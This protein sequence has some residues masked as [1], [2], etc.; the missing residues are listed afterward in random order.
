M[1]IIAGRASAAYGAGFGKGAT[2]PSVQIE[3]DY[4]SISSTHIA[5]STA[6]FT[7]ENIPTDFQ[8]LELR[9]TSLSNRATYGYDPIQ[10][11]VN[12][13]L[14]AAYPNVFLRG[15]GA[16]ATVTTGASSASGTEN[17]FYLDWGSGTT[18]SNYP[19]TGSIFFFDANSS[20]KYKSIHARYGVDLN[21]TIGGAAGSVNYIGGAY[22]G[23]APITSLRFS[24]YLGN[25]FQAG[26]RF[27]L[28]GVK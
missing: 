26:S 20:T 1:P 7:I 18:V 13:D 21:G 15:T 9:Y 28:Y 5:S 3:G 4:F 2:G 17:G 19:A 22:L 14:S 25:S 10:I 11:A 27:D 23:F 12:G 16:N 24:L 6:T 8:H